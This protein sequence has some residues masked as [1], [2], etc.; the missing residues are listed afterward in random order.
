MSKEEA[1]RKGNR[2]EQI[3]GDPVFAEA[4]DAV[5]ARLV[6]IMGEAKT[7]EATLKAKQ[8]LGLLNDV[9]QH[10][11]R[12]MTDGLVAAEQIKLEDEEK[13]RRGWFS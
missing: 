1:R 4:F 5:K 9:R 6:K 2:A 7:D 11:S 3:L 10:L 8:C 13:K 12:V